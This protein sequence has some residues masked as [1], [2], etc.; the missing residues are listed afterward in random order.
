[1]KRTKPT[2]L[3]VTIAVVVLVVVLI[4]RD[5]EAGA[6]FPVADNQSTVRG[7]HPD[8]M[9][10]NP[11]ESELAAHPLSITPSASNAF[12]RVIELTRSATFY[13]FDPTIVAFRE[14]TNRNGYHVTFSTRTHAA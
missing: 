11:V 12:Q 13:R 9:V 3:T 1:M 5:Q 4:R 2:L 6:E 14:R 7:R 10:T 8:L